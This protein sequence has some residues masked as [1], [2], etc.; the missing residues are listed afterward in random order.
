[1]ENQH[2]SPTSTAVFREKMYDISML[3]PE[4][5]QE[6]RPCWYC[7]C[8]TVPENLRAWKKHFCCDEHRK[9]F[10]KYGYLEFDRIMLNVREEMQKVRVEFE[11]ELARVKQDIRLGRL[12]RIRQTAVAVKEEV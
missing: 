2:T 10:N 8:W 4:N 9:A 12:R 6:P 1:M 5:W 7:G 11:R 3:T